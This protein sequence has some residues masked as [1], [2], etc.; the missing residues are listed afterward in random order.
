M[1]QRFT[2]ELVGRGPKGAWVFLPI[3]F[4]VQTVFGSKARVAVAG[5]VNGAPFQNSLLPN[6]DGTH[7]MPVNKELLA[8]ANAKVGEAVEVVL[9]VD[10]APRTVTPPDDLQSALVASEGME[11]AFG[12]LS[13]S[14]QKELVDWIA[15]AKKPETRA[16][17]VEKSLEMLRTGQRLKG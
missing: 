6:G 3:P 9:S 13:Y 5:T 15:G 10:T 7:S 1:E 11:Q 8:S 14:H 17:R 4:D 16:R 12:Q 2:S